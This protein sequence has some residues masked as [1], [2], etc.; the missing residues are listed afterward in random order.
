MIFKQIQQ[1][2]RQEQ[3]RIVRLRLR[4]DCAKSAQNDSVTFF[5]NAGER[6]TML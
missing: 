6:W 2:L 5:A 1:K 3:T 4:K